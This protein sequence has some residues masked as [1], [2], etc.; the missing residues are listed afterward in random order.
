MKLCTKLDQQCWFNI[1]VT[2]Y[3]DHFAESHQVSIALID[4]VI[5]K[6]IVPIQIQSDKS[7]PNSSQ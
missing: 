2:T 4:I 7:D 5:F 6:L 3:A 1:D